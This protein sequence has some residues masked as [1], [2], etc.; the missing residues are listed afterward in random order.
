M[1]APLAKTPETREE[2]EAMARRD[3]MFS[4]LATN[5]DRELGKAIADKSPVERRMLAD[6]AQYWGMVGGW[7][8]EDIAAG[9][10]QT[11]R[12]RRGMPI[13]NKTRSKTRI[14]SARIGDMLFPTNAPNW[15]MRPTPYPDVAVELVMEEYKKQQALEPPPPQP[16]QA[17]PGPEGAP[18]GAQP[19]MD[20]PAAPPVAPDYDALAMKVAQKRCRKMRQRIRDV[21]SENKYAKLGRAAI[22]DGCKVGTG[23]VKSPYVRFKTKRSYTEAQDG[24]GS[25]AVLNV[26]RVTVPGVARVSPWMFFPARARCIEESEHS[27]ELHILNKVQLAQMT[28]THGFYPRQIAKLLKTKPSLGAVESI[29]SQRAAITNYSMDRYENS[30]SVWEYHGPIDVTVLRE[31][32]YDIPEDELEDL[33]HQFGT[34]WMSEHEVL[35]VDMAPLEA[36]SALPYNVWC[37]ED[38]ETHVFGFGVPWVMRDDQYVIDMLWT[39][40]LHN[41]SI[42]SGPQIAIEKGVMVPADGNYTI[43]G[44]K[45]W[46]KNDIDI[47]ITQA[48]EA[49]VIPSTLN[50]T[51]P[52]YEKA[53]Q[54]ADD[55]T[56]LPLMLGDGRSTG[57]EGGASGMVHIAMMNQMNIVPRQA[58]HSW[59]DNI[60]TP[61]ISGLYDWFMQSND[62]KDE[63]LRGD[64]DVE[65]LGAS[66]LLIKDTQAQHI[67]LVM[68]MAAGDPAMAARLNMEEVYRIY[69]MHLDVP[70]DSMIKTDEEIAA[71]EANAKP[72][73][74]QAAQLAEIESKTNLNNA[75]AEAEQKR[76][77]AALKDA[78][79]QNIQVIDHSEMMALELRYAEM[80]DKQNDRDLQLQLKL[81]D[82]ETKLIEIA[83]KEGL[84]YDT[85]NAKISGEREKMLA[86]LQITSSQQQ[87]KDYFDAARLRLDQY[88]EELRTANMSRGFD[89]FG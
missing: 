87:S 67:Q 78:E 28:K 12:T 89:S 6:E 84:A 23:I 55:N 39:A 77:D 26:E 54:N 65:A 13:D 83:S 20:A 29:M 31:M 76:G 7:D 85:L 56:N 24:E 57:Q 59:D 52:V 70:V 75:R 86:D 64:Y 14:A 60:T 48:I 61:V 49:F 21:L 16:Q 10:D 81:I 9:H 68:Q 36:T 27:F 30:Y 2:L 51:M 44:P 82:R 62:P 35:R 3:E 5:L 47:P 33:M 18:Q 74:M 38:D 32:G 45:L 71:D 46:Y 15:G 4:A 50:S 66:H 40:I 22:F 43:D 53:L 1:A 34:V 17:P 41:V 8:K 73:P 80:R 63:E 42:S 79:G 37:Y 72:D 25:L 19:M 69:L 11:G 88:K 58:A